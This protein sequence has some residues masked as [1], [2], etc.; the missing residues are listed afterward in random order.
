M[1]GERTKGERMRGDPTIGVRMRGLRT[2]GERMRGVKT[3]KRRDWED[4]GERKSYLRR[5]NEWR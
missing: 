2:I 1:T 3:W 4:D 5:E